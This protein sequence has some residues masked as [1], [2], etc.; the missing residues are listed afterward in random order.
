VK[1]RLTAHFDQTSDRPDEEQIANIVSFN[2]RHNSYQH[3]SVFM[4][5]DCPACDGYGIVP[6]SIDTECST[7]EGTGVIGCA[8]GDHPD[9]LAVLS[10]YEHGLCKWMV[11]ASTVPDFGGFDTAQV[12]GVMVW[13][14]GDIERPW[15]DGLT[16]EARKDILDGIAE[17]Y[18]NWANG[19]VFGYQLVEL[20]ECPTCHNLEEGKEVDALWGHI[21]AEWFSDSIS[22]MIHGFDIDPNDVEVTGEAADYVRIRKLA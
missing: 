1:Y 9:V 19:D 14:G 2:S 21:G 3:P 7:C 15:W 18:T 5:K 13:N 4:E 16:D 10:Y 20:N 12:A 8:V 17:E 6:L 22:D 11:G